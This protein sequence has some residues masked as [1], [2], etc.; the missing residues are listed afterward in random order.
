[1]TLNDTLKQMKAASLSRIPAD[2]A[3]VMANANAQL[4][5][6]GIVEMTLGR[7][8][9]APGFKLQDWQGELFDSTEILSRGP[10]VL[11]FFRGSW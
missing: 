8:Q 9:A 5:A 4:E 11:T 7:G 3:A 6:S 1:M 2:A 10:L